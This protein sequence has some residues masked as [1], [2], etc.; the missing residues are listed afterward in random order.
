MLTF[1]EEMISLEGVS[2]A[3]NETGLDWVNNETV[4]V[5]GIDLPVIQIELIPGP[6]SL[7]ENLG[8]VWEAV[9]QT[10]HHLIIQINFTS[11][12]N[13]STHEELDILRVTINHPLLWTAPNGL[14]LKGWNR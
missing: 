4:D 7:A 10:S 5:N 1:T 2:F 8:L 3:A 12:R 13:V 11:P 9:N 6:D 14:V